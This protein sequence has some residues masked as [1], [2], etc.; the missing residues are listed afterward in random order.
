MEKRH[1]PEIKCPLCKGTAKLIKKN[2]KL[3]KG[4]ATLKGAESYKCQK[5]GEIF[6]TSKQVK[7]SEKRIRNEFFFKRKIISTGGSLA[8]TLPSDLSEYY[9]LEK[10]TTISIVPEG[11]NAIKII[12]G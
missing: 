8:I 12:T 3:S 7:E 4:K 9:K 10:G 11:K 5:C 2:I 1:K 6:S